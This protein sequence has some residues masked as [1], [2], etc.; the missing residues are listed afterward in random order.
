MTSERQMGVALKPMVLA[1]CRRVNRCDDRLGQY[2]DYEGLG[3]DQ[4]LPNGD[5][6]ADAWKSCV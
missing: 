3:R 6:S 1:L 5:S 4:T 2:S